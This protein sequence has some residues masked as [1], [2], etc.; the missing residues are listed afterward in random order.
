M[1]TQ[2]QNRRG[3]TAEHSSFTGAVGELTVDTDKDVLVVHDG[4]T[5]GGHPMLKQDG[6]NSALALGSASSPSLKFS[7]DPNTGIYSPGADQLAISSN[8]VGR[9]FI[10]ASGNVGV[11]TATFGNAIFQ[12]Q[13][14]TTL[15][16][17]ADTGVSFTNISTKTYP[18]TSGFNVTPGL[19]QSIE[20]GTAQVIDTV[21]PG[22]FNNV[23][24]TRFQLTKSAGNTQDIERLYFFG[25]HQTFNW[26]DGN[27]CKQYV[28]ITDIFTYGGI[29]ANGRT[30]SLIE[31][32]SVN[33]T[34]PAGGTQT[35]A[36]VG[37]LKAVSIRP[38]DGSTVNITNGT[39]VQPNLSIFN[40][41]SGTKTINV[42]NYS[43]FE[44]SP[45]WGVQ[46]SGGTLNATITNLFGLRLRPPTGSA[47]L[48][49]TNNWGLYQE[50]S[51]A[52]NWFAGASNQFPNITTTASG[53]NAFLDSA[54][55]NRLYLSTSS[56][57]YKRDVED[58]D[59]T[60]A[61]KILGLRP[62][63]YRSKCKT[64][65]QEWSWYGLIAEEVAEVDPRFVH[66]GYQEDAYELVD[67]TETVQL[68]PDDPRLK[69]GIETEE[70]TRQRR[71]LKADAQRVPNG[72]AYER[73]VVP[74]LDII[75]R[76]K[77][78]LESFEAR[79]AAL[80]AQ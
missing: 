14:P 5:A 80:E 1:A 47:G 72:V 48:T 29:N 70:V 8:G 67:V 27:T 46:G 32:F 4:S 31:G 73:L 20:L 42:S 17:T 38:G 75:K 61:D 79:L 53:A 52:K 78:Q 50:W 18:T 6:S 22:G 16:T 7:G 36:I 63:W 59:S 2:V 30:T 51:S 33:L 54:D 28:A 60:L 26:T 10:D 77:S 40:T 34:P 68:Q 65:C 43:F 69:E 64:D 25:L 35:I 44:T 62:V 23:Y 21:T 3:T 49:I 66:Y 12:V 58:L 37:G 11:G 41:A 13:T 55:S 57:A 24:G 45:Y 76:Q 39:G 19:A 74:L 15:S 9:L 71:Q 56:I